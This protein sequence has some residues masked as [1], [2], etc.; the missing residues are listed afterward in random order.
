MSEEKT[1][2]V[3]TDAKIKHEGLI[4]PMV[5]VRT[6][7]AGG[8]GTVLF[9]KACNITYED[10]QSNI[11]SEVGEWET[12]VLTNHHVIEDAI[13][14]VKK[15]SPLAKREITVELRKTVTCEFFK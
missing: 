2:D 11:V 12:Y 5:R 6:E 13:K 8:S 15:W 10:P 9:S 7:K 1:V 14:F 4:F 3:L